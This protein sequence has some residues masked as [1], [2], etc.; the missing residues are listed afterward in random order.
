M[1]VSSRLSITSRAPATFR[2]RAAVRG[3]FLPVG[4]GRWVEEAF[5]HCTLALEEWRFSS[6]PSSHLSCKLK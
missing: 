1:A 4:D 2:D 3:A 6:N 5:P